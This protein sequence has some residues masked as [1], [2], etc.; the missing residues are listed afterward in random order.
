M[1]AE[2]LARESG[3]DRG[4]LSYYL[5]NKKS[6]TVETIERIARA[7]GVDIMELFKP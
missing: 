4:H 5:A 6:A 1:L 3:V 2:H 7:L